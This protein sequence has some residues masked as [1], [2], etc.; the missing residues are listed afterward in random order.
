[1]IIKVVELAKVNDTYTSL[2]TESDERKSRFSLCETFLN[3]D[4]VVSFREVDP[5]SYNK[6]VLPEGLDPRQLFTYVTLSEIRRG[7]TVVGSPSE[8]QKKINK[9]REPEL[10]RG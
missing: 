6:E 3:T 7:I 5:D 1:M 2:D 10:L 8:L 4:H 9:A